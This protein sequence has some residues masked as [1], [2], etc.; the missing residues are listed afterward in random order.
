[1]KEFFATYPL[2]AWSIV[3]TMLAL[4]AVTILWDKIKW[5]WHNTWYSF[6]L[7]GKLATLARDG[8]ED[9]ANKGWFKAE[10]ALCRDYKK[11]VRIKDEHD[12]NENITY[13]T[14]AGDN[15][16][17]DTPGWIWLLTV[18]MVFVEAM[19]FSYVLAGYTLPGASENLQQTGAY[20]IAFLISVI[21]VAFTHFAGHELYKSNL[22]KR[23]RR[24]WGEDGRKGKFSTGTVPLAR[25]QSTDDGEPPYTQLANRVGTHPS[26]VIGISTAVFV[27]LIA[28]FATFVRG[29]VLEKELQH[30]ITAQTAQTQ[31]TADATNSGLDMS[32]SSSAGNLPDADVASSKQAD[33]KA[34]RD[35]AKLDGQAGWG[36]FIVLAFVF[37]F[38][39]ILGVI[40]GYRWGFA[41]ENSSRAYRA[42][43]KGRYATYAD[44]REHYDVVADAA[45][46]KLE[47]L[48]QRLME[49]NGAVGNSGQHASK[50]FR[51]FMHETRVEQAD[52]RSKEKRIPSEMGKQQEQ[53]PAAIPTPTP[54]PAQ[55]VLDVTGALARLDALGDDKA[56]KKAFLDTLPPALDAEVRAALKARKEKQEADR[57]AQARD[58]ELEDLL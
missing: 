50:T 51:D 34:V 8:N 5:W 11:F 2:F 32:A 24:E 35:E 52:E 18:A 29:Q 7:I 13:L 17:S 55:A 43:G 45:Q 42:I 31:A 54:A 53:A 6:P 27:V 38:L 23:A 33:A 49:K 47:T 22:I 3:S 48:Q 40:F 44:V 36:T 21:L 39:Q 16:R 41:G 12:F 14:K 28:G 4:V 58:A 46:A 20:G 30:R 37:V 10:R 19:G 25:P 26:F 1:M 9:Q 57:Q 56:A 15:G